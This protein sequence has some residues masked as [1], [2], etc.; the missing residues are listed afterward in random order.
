[1]SKLHCLSVLVLIFQL[2]ISHAQ[3]LGQE[4]E[5]A[6]NQSKPEVAGFWRVEPERTNQAN[7]ESRKEMRPEMIEVLN[8][9]TLRLSSDG[10][11]KQTMGAS[12]EIRGEWKFEYSESANDVAGGKFH[13]QLVLVPDNLDGHADMQFDVVFVTSDL[14]EANTPQGVGTVFLQRDQEP[15]E[16]PQQEGGDEKEQDVDR[17]ARMF[18]DVPG[19][20]GARSL[21]KDG[22][23]MSFVWFEDREAVISWCESQKH[24]RT[25]DT[26]LKMADPELE[27]REPLAAAPDEQGPF[28]VI[29]TLKTNADREAGF[30]LEQLSMEIYKPVDGGMF[31]G[32][33]FAPK[34]LKVKGLREILVK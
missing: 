2:S 7:A 29:M 6:R 11:F 26:I 21:E 1:M 22:V 25:A 18:A 15:S 16:D 9:M 4:R 12:Q 17:A 10:S 3:T 32:D 28:L 5:V 19:C 33:R 30:P 14:I 31:L 34:E 23:Q 20:L 8:G 13:G 27:M 24:M